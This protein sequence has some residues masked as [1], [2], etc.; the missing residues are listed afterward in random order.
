MKLLKLIQILITFL[1][2][3]LTVV[4]VSFLMLR[5]VLKEVRMEAKAEWAAFARAVPERNDL[6]PGLIE[7]FK[8][9]ESGHT[10]LAERLLHGTI[11]L[12][13]VCR[14]RPHRRSY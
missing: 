1:L 10:K 14:S 13:A 2:A 11:H 12:Y 6:I 5:P 9:F 3:F 7:S 4:V 8:G